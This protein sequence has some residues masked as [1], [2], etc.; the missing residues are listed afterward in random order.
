MPISQFAP[1]K[2]EQ[3]NKKE[4]KKKYNANLI[5]IAFLREMES[6]DF[7]IVEEDLNSPKN[8]EYHSFPG[9]T[10]GF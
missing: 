7:S 4:S 6:S 3:V 1:A 9:V 8:I 10:K 5:L 2:T